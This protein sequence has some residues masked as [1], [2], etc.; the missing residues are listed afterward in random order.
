MRSEPYSNKIRL[1]LGA[2]GTRPSRLCGRRASSPADADPAGETPAV[3]TGPRP[4][5]RFQASRCAP[6]LS[7][8]QVRTGCRKR[9]RASIRA[10][11][12]GM[13]ARPSRSA[14]QPGIRTA[15]VAG[16]GGAALRHVR[17]GATRRAAGA[18]RDRRFLPA[19]LVTNFLVVPALVWALAR[20]LPP[21]TAL[22]LGVYLV[23]LVPCTDWYVSFT[24]L[25]GGDARRAIASTPVLLLAQMIAL[26]LYL[27]LFLGREFTSIARVGGFLE[28]FAG[29]I[30]LPLL[31]ALATEWGARR[32]RPVARWLARTAWLPVPLLALTVF[33]IAGAQVRIVA[34]SWELLGAAGARL[35][36]L[37]R[38]HSVPR[39]MDRAAVRPRPRRPAHPGL[40]HGHTQ[41]LRGAAVCARAAAGMAAGHR[42]DRPANPH[43]ACGDDRLSGVDSPPRRVEREL[44]T[45]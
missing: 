17:A 11:R 39:A 24:R 16:P 40:Q 3:H 15:L 14:E 1:V 42:R 22:V 35:P 12:G 18:A 37:R 9:D 45:G 8:I 43:R 32:S 23:L 36:R 20:L 28:A 7:A 34:D 13:R 5:L 21:D 6:Y 31:P 41:F 44:V 33:L 4:V 2:N 26:P 29:L 27:W 25:G 19:L 10:A 30:L 38:G